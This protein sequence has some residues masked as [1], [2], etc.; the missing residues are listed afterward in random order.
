MNNV[1][2]KRWLVFNPGPDGHRLDFDRKPGGQ[3]VQFQQQFTN[4]E[5]FHQRLRPALRAEMLLPRPLPPL[6]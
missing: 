4:D 3:L 1:N 5:F 2:Q 6:Y